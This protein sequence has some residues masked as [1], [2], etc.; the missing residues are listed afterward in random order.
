MSKKLTKANF[1]LN[2]TLSSLDREI[3]MSLVE[4]NALDS[5]ID[6]VKKAADEAYEEYRGLEVDL[7]FLK[8]KRESKYK[9]FRELYQ[10]KLYYGID[11]DDVATL[12][13]E[14]VALRQAVK[15]S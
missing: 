15:D 4:L 7:K 14:V 11:D 2:G 10:K 13:D 1:K 6:A 12:I 8:F 9:E 3:Y 5:K